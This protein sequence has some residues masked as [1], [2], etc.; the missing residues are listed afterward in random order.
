MSPTVKDPLE[1]KMISKVI[2][3]SVFSTVGR[4]IIGCILFDGKL[5]KRNVFYYF[6]PLFSVMD[7][8]SQ[9]GWKTFTSIYDNIFLLILSNNISPHVKPHIRKHMIKIVGLHYGIKLSVRFLMPPFHFPSMIIHSLVTCGW[10]LLLL[11]WNGIE[12]FM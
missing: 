5:C 4:F 9:L 10:I 12:T 2:R 3:I 6:P 11:A 1:K 7:N 8:F